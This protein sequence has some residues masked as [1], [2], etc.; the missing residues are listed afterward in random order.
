MEMEAH[1]RKNLVAENLVAQI[2]LV[3]EIFRVTQIRDR[4]VFGMISS[5]NQPGYLG[6][7]N[8]SGYRSQHKSSQSG[9][10]KE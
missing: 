5:F 4:M 3:V 10:P 2:L 7:P 8:E 9:F 1:L 6:Y